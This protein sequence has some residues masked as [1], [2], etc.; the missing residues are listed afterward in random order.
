MEYVSN[1]SHWTP[2]IA[3]IGNP[4][5]GY[6]VN[7]YMYNSNDTFSPPGPPPIE[8]WLPSVL[9]YAITFVVGLIGNVLVIFSIQKCRSLQ[10][11]TNT[12]LASLAT[13]DLIIVVIVIPFQTPTYFLWKWELGETVCKLLP[14]LTL[15]SSASSVFMLT[16]LSIERYFVIVHPLLAKSMITPGRARKIILTVWIFALVYSFPPLYYKRLIT[17]DFPNYTKYYTCNTYWPN[18]DLGKAFSVYLLLGIYLIPLFI[19]IF[20]YS[21]I[22]YELWISAKRCHQMQQR[23][24]G[25]RRVY[26]ASPALSERGNEKIYTESGITISRSSEVIFDEQEEMSKRRRTRIDVDHGRKQ[27]IVMLLLVVALFM[28]CWGPLIWF[29]FL[30]EFGFFPRLHL[31][32][33]YL[34][35]AFNLLSYLN[36]CMN[37]ICYAF[38]SRTFRQCF[39][40]ACT[41]S[42]VS[43]INDPTRRRGPARNGTITT[44]STATSLY[45]PVSLGRLRNSDVIATPE[46]SPALRRSTPRS[47]PL[48]VGSRSPA[49]DRNYIRKSP[50]SSPMTVRYS[51]RLGDRC[52]D[53][54]TVVW[55]NKCKAS[56]TALTS[57]SHV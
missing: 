42:C 11:V 26:R 43:S 21:R 53:T 54:A 36:S 51:T 10:N 20:C 23:P 34:G 5:D 52:H 55:N 35:I 9:V 22:I 30:I 31:T 37:P 40:W 32:R 50:C 41:A 19:M 47:S 29:V 33:T 3:A 17:H 25:A 7:D 56:P 18:G 38:I 6:S 2:T 48:L 46:A 24:T 15:L 45:R 44:K 16:T 12:F 4:S 13:A 49:R 1:S 57:E 8:V 39:K 28:I 27:V 14:Y